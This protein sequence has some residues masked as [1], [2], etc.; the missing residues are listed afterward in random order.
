MKKDPMPV[1]FISY[2]RGYILSRHFRSVRATFRGFILRWHLWADGIQANAL[3]GYATCPPADPR[4]GF[5]AGWTMR[6]F[7]D[8]AREA[9]GTDVIR[10]ARR[11]AASLS[12]H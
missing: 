2:L 10:T 4:T 5:P 3:P 1:E 12:A 8:I 9:F 6:K 7:N 11:R